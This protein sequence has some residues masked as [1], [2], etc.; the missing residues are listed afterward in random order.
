MSCDTLKRGNDLTD[1]PER[2]LDQYIQKRCKPLTPPSQAYM[3]GG[4]THRSP[5]RRHIPLQPDSPFAT[6]KPQVNTEEYM[7]EM[8]RRRTRKFLHQYAARRADQMGLQQD[9][10]TAAA[11]AAPLSPLQ[12]HHQQ[13][14]HQL[15]HQQQQHHALSPLS[16]S[17][18][19]MSLQQQ[20]QQ[21]RCE[22]CGKDKRLREEEMF[23]QEQVKAM[24]E[25]AV[26]DNTETLREEFGR[27]LEER[28]QEQYHFFLKFNEDHI[29]RKLS[30]SPFV[31]TS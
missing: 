7:E 17:P 13:Q 26:S 12:Q 5:A 2:P 28:L 9:D 23:P 31:Y 8:K 3:P 20:Q 16:L 22:M 18:H 1:A 24:I 10:D 27:I 4:L 6:V 21:H 19:A 15:H 14:H 11:A 30:E 25:R 29:H